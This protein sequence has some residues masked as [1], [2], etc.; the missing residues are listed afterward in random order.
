MIGNDLN[1]SGSQPPEDAPDVATLKADIDKWKSLSRVNEK[2]WNAASAELDSLRKEHSTA[3]D[4]HR[5][6][7]RRL[8]QAEMKAQAAMSGIALSDGFLSLLDCSKLI[9][10]GGD[11]SADAIAL[12]LTQFR[13]AQEAEFTQGLGLGYHQGPLVPLNTFS[14]DARNR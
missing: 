5:E 13:A 3:V 14:L 8:A 6:Y 11:P 9:D 2:R 4:L 12:V 10:E 7:A 1:P